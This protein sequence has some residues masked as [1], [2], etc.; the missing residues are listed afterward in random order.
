[1]GEDRPPPGPTGRR[2]PPREPGPVR[3]E[4]SGL[5]VRRVACDP[6]LDGLL[7]GLRFALG[8]GGDPEADTVRWTPSVGQES[9]TNTPKAHD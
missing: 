6:L 2:E 5:P 3:P 9:R 7:A 1:M 4:S 8:T